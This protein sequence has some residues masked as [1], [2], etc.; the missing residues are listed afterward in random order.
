MAMYD[1]LRSKENANN[2]RISL[3]TKIKIVEPY[4]SNSIIHNELYNGGPK[5]DEVVGSLPKHT[6]STVFLP[7]HYDPGIAHQVNEVDEI[8]GQC[9]HLRPRSTYAPDHFIT[10]FTYGAAVIPMM[11]LAIG[12][13]FNGLEGMVEL[14]QTE[15]FR[16][17]MGALILLNGFVAP[18]YMRFGPDR[19]GAVEKVQT[20]LHEI[21]QSRLEQMDC[22]KTNP[23]M[24]PIET[25][26][27]AMQ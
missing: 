11:S 18:I 24:R 4:E 22:T 2:G 19:T 9:D 8:I 26:S 23:P 7:A 25:S 21:K 1:T 5:L 17:L 13:F 14:A 27:Q 16:N 6:W 15:E 3:E 12:Y 10:A 20:V